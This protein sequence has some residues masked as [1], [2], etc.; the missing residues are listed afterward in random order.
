MKEAIGYR[1]VSTREQGRSGLGLAA[2][3]DHILAFG[4]QEGFAIRSWFQDI[5]TGAGRDA[6][7]LRPGLAAALKAARAQRCPLI[8]SKLDRLSRN[9]HFITGLLEHRVQSLW[10][11]HPGYTVKQLIAASGPSHPLGTTRAQTLLR[12]CRATAA[13]RSA[14][15]QQVG[16]PLDRRTTARIRIAALW[17]RHPEYTAQQVIRALGPAPFLTVPWVQR[18]L[19]ECSRACG[20]N[21]REDWRIGRRRYHSWRAR[22]STR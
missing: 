21:S 17:K 5:Q 7:L 19:K 3:R 22:P 6:L 13:K 2:Q 8:V 20:R 15:H 12:E 16:W 14:L 18:I 4:A 10:E 1:R 11:D 9:V